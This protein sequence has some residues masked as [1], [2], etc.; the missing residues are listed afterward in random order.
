MLRWHW[1]GPLSRQLNR[2]L[3]IGQSES[4]ALDSNMKTGSHTYTSTSAPP[5]S[6]PW[7]GQGRNLWM[8]G[9][10]ALLGLVVLAS[11]VRLVDAFWGGPK[12]QRWKGGLVMGLK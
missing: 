12:R 9:P 6:G 3:G 10:L 8:L 2:L 11:Q 1:R 5:L 7:V 4:S